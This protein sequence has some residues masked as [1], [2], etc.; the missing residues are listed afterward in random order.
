MINSTCVLVFLIAAAIWA[1]IGLFW[2][3]GITDQEPE[4]TGSVSVIMRS[5]PV[6]W[7]GWVVFV[8]LL[9]VWQVLTCAR[10]KLKPAT[11]FFRRFL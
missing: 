8:T 7:L 4:K 3:I 2:Y 11:A 9:F 10:S 6:V 5:G 1:V